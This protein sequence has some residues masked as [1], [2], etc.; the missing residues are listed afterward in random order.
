[1]KYVGRATF[2]QKLDAASKNLTT[3]KKVGPVYID[4]NILTLK[5]K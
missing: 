1:M 5:V 2:A 3:C 4:E